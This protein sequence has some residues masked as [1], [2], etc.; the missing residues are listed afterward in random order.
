MS[1]LVSLC[2]CVHCKFS[3]VLKGGRS[4]SVCSSDC[5]LTGR[6][7]LKRKG[8]REALKCLC[9]ALSRLKCLGPACPALSRFTC[10]TNA[11]RGVLRGLH[12]LS[13]ASENQVFFFFYQVHIVREK[14]VND[15]ETLAGLTGC[16]Y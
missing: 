3:G 15:G 5:S 16:S 2:A 4:C 14:F 1:M 8:P 12:A 10:W 9:P 11:G 7:E 13:H 6:W